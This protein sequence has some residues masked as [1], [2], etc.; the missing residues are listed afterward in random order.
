M[1]NGGERPLRQVR[2]GALDSGAQLAAVTQDPA[3]A[4]ARACS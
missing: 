2:Q 3:V 1:K 4:A